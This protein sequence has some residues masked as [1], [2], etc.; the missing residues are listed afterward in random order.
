MHKFHLNFLIFIFIYW[1]FTCVYVYAPRVCL[2]L[3]EPCLGHQIPWNR[4]GVRRSYEPST[5]RRLPGRAANALSH[6]GF[7]LAPTLN[8]CSSNLQERWGYRRVLYVV[9]GI[10]ST[11][12]MH[13][14]QAVHQPS[15]IY[16]SG[17]CLFDRFFFF[18][19]GFCFKILHLK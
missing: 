18:K 1:C 19:K 7:S 10:E 6:S 5:E 2:T 9:L 15:Y 4:N 12:F 11:I 17:Y 3:A 8:Y 16:S 14:G 13:V